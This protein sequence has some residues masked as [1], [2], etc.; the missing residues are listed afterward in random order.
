MIKL[1]K[2]EILVEHRGVEN[3]MTRDSQGTLDSG[4]GGPQTGKEIIAVIF[5]PHKIRPNINLVSCRLTRCG[6]KLS[7]S[8]FLQGAC[9]CY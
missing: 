5:R 9:H 8:D 6:A 4:L 2:T 3:K 1:L 7:A